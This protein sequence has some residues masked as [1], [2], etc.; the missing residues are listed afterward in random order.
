LSISWLSDVTPR[1]TIL[2]LP[3]GA[4]N[5]DEAHAAIELWEHY[6]KRRLDATQRLV[7]EVMM[8]T[9]ADGRWAAA[10][11]GR[12][13]ARQNGKGDETEVV[14]LWGLVQRAER[15]MHTIHEAVLLSTETQSRLLT[16]IEANTDLR[17]LKARAWQ[18]TGQQM[19]EM[20]NGGVI[21]Y[22]TRSSS[23]G[24]RGVDEVD[25]VVLDEAQHVEDEHVTGVSPTLL[26]SANPQ[27]NAMGTSGIAGKS[28]WWWKLRRRAL[29]GSAA[30]FGYVG[31]T[32]EQIALVDGKLERT[33]IDPQDRRNWH[34]ANP[35][36]TRR[37][38]LIE[39]LEEQMLR[40]GPELFAR[41]HLGVWD[42]PLEDL[43]HRDVKLPADKWATTVTT[44]I[45]AD[46][47]PGESVLTFDVSRDGEWSSVAIA[48]GTRENPYVEV[49]K[50][51]Q[52]TSWLSG[53]LVEV[54]QRR[55]PSK[56]IC[57]NAGPASAVVGTVLEAFAAAG[58]SSD[59]LHLLTASEYKGACGAFYLAVIDGKLTHPPDQGPLDLAAADATERALSGAWVW[60]V[61]QATVPISPLVA[62]TIAPA[63]LPVEAPIPAIY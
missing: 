48:M 13:A 4:V 57:N 20:R 49:I 34:L 22:R 5:L 8:A 21:W 19:I 14:E 28:E 35:A 56:V 17:R 39:F 24:G 2:V 6:K 37:P 29:G 30:G 42:P 33:P 45:P 36:L 46:P 12:E 58:I 50:H 26:A 38:E 43:E 63:F 7:V 10:T 41:E 23:G 9:R 54:H 15:I 11:T 32:A 62:V 25:R 1:P 53:Y 40:L 3:A 44:K 31:H 60:D 18:G 52:G 27:L 59:E 51:Q 47:K 55:K 16:T 61:R